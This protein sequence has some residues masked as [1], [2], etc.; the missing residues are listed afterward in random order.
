MAAV[1]MGRSVVLSRNQRNYACRCCWRI[2]CT[3]CDVPHRP[4]WMVANY[5]VL[6]Q[7]MQVALVLMALVALLVASRDPV[8]CHASA[9]PGLTHP[10]AH[11]IAVGCN[12]APVRLPWCP[13]LGAGPGL[14][15]LACLVAA[16]LL[17]QII[18]WKPLAVSVPEKRFVVD[19]VCG[20]CPL[21][22]CWFAAA[23][24]GLDLPRVCPVHGLPWAV[25]S[26]LIIGMVTCTA[27]GHLGRPLAT[28]KTIPHQLL[29]DPWL[30]LSCVCCPL[31]RRSQ[32]LVAAR[33][34]LARSRA[35]PLP[36]AVRSHAHPPRL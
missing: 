23:C 2:G 13:L 26:L 30:P 7:R 9:T 3:R 10:D 29:A 17:W 4:H 16:G 24:R 27:L 15:A 28:D 36:V 33:N 32:A 22:W 6:M 1:G 5:A 34:G 14:T 8:L 21:A 11:P 20:L 19:F 12:W 31:L 25:S 35:W 18:A